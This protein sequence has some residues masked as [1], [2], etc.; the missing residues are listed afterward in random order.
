VN[1]G[2]TTIGFHTPAGPVSLNMPFIVNTDLV[3]FDA[4]QS[5]TGTWAGW[6]IKISYDSSIISVQYA[7]GTG[8]GC[9]ASI[10]G[11]P[12]LAPDI[13]TGCALQRN[14]GTGYLDNIVLACINDGTS[15]LHFVIGD[16][17]G[18]VLFDE[19]ANTIPTTFVDSSITCDR[20][21]DDDGDGCPSSA[22]GALGLD[23]MNPWD[24][25]SVPVPAL[26][27]APDPRLDFKDNMVAVGDA[28]AVF[29]Y[30][31]AGAHLG[32]PLYEQDLNGNGVKD[33]VE[34]DRSAAGPALTGAPDGAISATDAQ[35][36]FAQFKANEK[37]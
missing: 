31:K 30:F 35:L 27:A 10:W 16:A 4:S 25:Y 22:E 12:S 8:L 20:H 17:D 3:A 9:P 23:P 33:G 13:V 29:G 26:F 24:F 28:Q 6:N 1:N 21:V 15:P 19:F 36:A 5:V 34:Y 37:C 18:S 14:T 7:T 32:G 11:N 2:P